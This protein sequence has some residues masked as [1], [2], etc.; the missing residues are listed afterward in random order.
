M[1]SETV[2]EVLDAKGFRKPIRIA[3]FGVDTEAFRPI[4]RETD[5][6]FTVGYIGR[7]MPQKGVL[8]LID[9][10]ARIKSEN[11]R[12]L[13]VGDG[14][15]RRTMERKL[16]EYGLRDRCRFVGAVQYDETP[17][18]FQKI[19]VLAMPT[20]TTKKI[21]E[22]FGRVLIEAMS[23]RVP[24]VGSTCGAIPEVIGDAGIVVPENDATALAEA[25]RSVMRDKNLQK[26]LADAGQRRVEE[27]FTWER[28]AEQIFSLYE[29]VLGLP[30]CEI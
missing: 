12:L 17:Q 24:V 23:C 1:C 20:I 3:Y 28:V 14:T 9:A 7:L 5:R 15:E 25:L 2:R 11:W 8:V 22:Q 18:Y 26:K 27:N 19:D 13:V 6:P 21:R 30:K 29:R 4:E 16:A 10:L